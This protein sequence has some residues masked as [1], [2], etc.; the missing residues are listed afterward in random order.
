MAPWRGFT[1]VCAPKPIQPQSGN[2]NVSALEARIAKLAQ[3]WEDDCS[4]ELL[5][6][7]GEGR[8][9]DLATR[10]R[11]F[12]NVYRED[13]SPQAGAEDAEILA[14]LSDASTT[15]REAVSSTRCQRRYVALQDL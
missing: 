14:S 4:A 5:R 6:T 2:V 1:T 11:C 15:G 10:L 13:F 3:R 9:L 8:G 7:H 12:P